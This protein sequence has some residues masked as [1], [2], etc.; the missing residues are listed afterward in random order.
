MLGSRPCVTARRPGAGRQAGASH[1]G[2][3]QTTTKACAVCCFT[4][5]GRLGIDL[6][7]VLWDGS[8]VP[9]ALPQ[10]VSPIAIADEGAVPAL[11]RRPTSRHNAQSL[12]D[13]PRRSAQ[14]QP[15]R[16]RRAPH[17]SADQGCAA[18]D[19]KEDGAARSCQVSA[20]AAWRAVAAGHGSRRPACRRQRE[21][22]PGKHRVPLRPVERVLLRSFSTPTWSTPARYFADP[23]DDL[24]TAQHNKLEMSC[25][26]LRL[27]PD[28]TLL[29]VGC[30]WGAFICHA[31]QHYGV[32]AHGV[33][34]SQ[35]QYD[36]AKE[37]IARLGLQD[38]V[39]AGTAGL[40]AGRRQL[41]QDRLDGDV[42]A[43]RHRQPSGLFPDH[44]PS[45]ETRRTLSAS[46]HQ[47]A[48]QRAATGR[49]AKNSRNM[50]RSR[51]TSFRAANSI[52]SA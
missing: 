21:H 50:R 16:S 5:H 1:E 37:K 20:R 8:T 34:L 47:P 9:S 2:R 13:R 31:A 30:G 14:R 39:T 41:R 44:Q 32:R 25:R 12:G 46:R 35:Q 38:R 51:A 48:G 40:R 17:E 3:G 6:G 4:S 28:E 11:M 15:V 52:I 22:Q 19:R 36:Y 23:A 49:S 43:R 7:F 10:D 24:S 33:T 26:R 42:R 45:A 18:N 27:R 29:D